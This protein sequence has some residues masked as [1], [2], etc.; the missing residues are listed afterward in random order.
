M[1][2]ALH[3]LASIKQIVKNCGIL[4]GGRIAEGLSIKQIVTNWGVAQGRVS[5]LFMQ[6]AGR[7]H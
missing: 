6:K 7:L 4:L 5:K 2:C 3:N 1:G